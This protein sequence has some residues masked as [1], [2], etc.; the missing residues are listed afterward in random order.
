M[1]FARLLQDSFVAKAMLKAVKLI[2]C[3]GSCG[4]CAVSGVLRCPPLSG[5]LNLSVLASLISKYRSYY[6]NIYIYT[7]IT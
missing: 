2:N 1:V 4:L 3:N 7:H 6:V 5:L